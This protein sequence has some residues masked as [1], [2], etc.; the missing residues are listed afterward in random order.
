MD[1][2]GGAHVTDIYP[3]IDVTIQSLNSLARSLLP[4]QAA[5]GVDFRD[6]DDLMNCLTRNYGNDLLASRRCAIR[7]RSYDGWNQDWRG[8]ILPI[9]K[10][11]QSTGS[12][13]ANMTFSAG[14]QS[15]SE[16][17]R[18]TS[19]TREG[20]ITVGRQDSTNVSITSPVLSG[21][22]AGANTNTQSTGSATTRDSTTY[23]N[24]YTQSNAHN[25]S[26]TTQVNSQRQ[27]TYRAI[28]GV[29]IYLRRVG[30]LVTD[31]R[32]SRVV[33]VGSVRYWQSDR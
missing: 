33:Q 6:D 18:S 8:Q 12:R 5:S 10:G 25:Q 9:I 24:T 32:G 22:S 30:H 21:A 7:Y 16:H 15:G 2:P 17:S 19:I 3:N 20:G 13:V 14:G 4:I 1:L 11:I 26:T 29:K 28:L 23:T 27:T 31:D